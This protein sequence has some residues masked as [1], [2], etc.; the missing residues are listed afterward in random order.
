MHH[1]PFGLHLRL[2]NRLVSLL[3]G[4]GDQAVSIPLRA[5][6]ER[7]ALALSLFANPITLG[8][9]LGQQ[10]FS[11]LPGIAAQ[12]LGGLRRLTD[13]DLGFRFGLGA[14]HGGIVGGPG[15]HPIGGRPGGMQN[16]SDL[17]ADAVELFLEIHLAG[18]I[19]EIL[20][21]IALTDQLG[22]SAGELVEVLAN[23]LGTESPQGRAE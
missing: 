12:S 18:L 2:A 9:G 4:V 21:A 7:Q 14:Q 13:R 5:T 20:E 8:H 15:A 11:G 22:H 19:G 6:D 23:R 3:T 16:L 1:Q 17:G 10:R